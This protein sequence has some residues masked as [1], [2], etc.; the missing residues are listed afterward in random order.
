MSVSGCV[1]VRDTITGGFV[2]FES[3]VSYLTV[4]DEYLVMDLGSTDGTLEILEEIAGHNSRIHLIK[5]SFPVVDA[6][7]FAT[8]ANDLI[9]LSRYPTV[10]YH[11]SDEVPHEQLL[12]LMKQRLLDGENDLSFWRVQLGWNFQ[13]PRWYPHLVHRIGPKNNFIFTGDGMNTDRVWAVPLCSTFDGGWFTKWGT[14]GP[15]GIK[16]AIHE[17]ILD[18]SLLGAFR[19]LI[20]GRRRMH[21]PFW[22]EE[23]LIE[24]KTTSDWLAE[25]MGDERWT[26]TE[27]PFAIPGVLRHHIGKTTYELRPELFEALKND[28]ADQFVAECAGWK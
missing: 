22:H 28:R 17:M 20:P 8:L 2:L 3:L 1:F 14:L 27:S 25:A 23:P 24:G 9:G 6:G 15:S 21:S 18:I 5:G 11:Q 19:D 10:L 16:D 13:S 12:R 7:A 26:R 4:V